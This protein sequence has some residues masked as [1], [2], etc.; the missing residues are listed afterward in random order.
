MTNEF[1][2]E[3]EAPSNLSWAEISSN[4][5]VTNID[6]QQRPHFIKHYAYLLRQASWQ[7]GIDWKPVSNTI[8][9][10]VPNDLFDNKNMDND[11]FYVDG[12]SV[13]LIRVLG[14]VDMATLKRHFIA[15]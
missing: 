9:L 6:I 4:L 1:I 10:T 7:H 11:G 12:L 15:Q 3:V 8:A 5:N 13:L 14:M 2:I